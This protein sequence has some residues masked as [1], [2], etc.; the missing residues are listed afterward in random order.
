MSIS[1]NVLE[2][3]RY[4]SC[5]M[6]RPVEELRCL[7]APLLGLSS[8]HHLLQHITVIKGANLHRSH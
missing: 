6:R 2:R 1:G 4:V 5:T 7:D 8:S 3:V